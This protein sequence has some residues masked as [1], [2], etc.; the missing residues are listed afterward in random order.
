MNAAPAITSVGPP[1]ERHCVRVV[2]EM[3]AF[4]HQRRMKLQ[5]GLEGALDPRRMGN[6]TAQMRQ[7]EKFRRL[8]G[9]TALDLQLTPAKR[10]KFLLSFTEWALYC[11]GAVVENAVLPPGAGIAAV[12]TVFSAANYRSEEISAALLVASR[13]SLDRLA[14]RADV[15]TV[16]ELLACIR[17]L[18]A[19]TTALMLAPDDAW[20]RPPHGGAWQVPIANGIAVLKPNED[21]SRSLVVVSIL[22]P[23]MANPAALAA[24]EALIAT[25]A[26]EIVEEDRQ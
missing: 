3:L 10:G 1:P 24:T 21:G 16:D 14:E 20:L 25:R 13:H 5:P 18:W 8:A 12:T 23:E 26:V 6:P 22:S 17:S 7:F 4:L 19:V 2:G 11:D 15:R 9:P